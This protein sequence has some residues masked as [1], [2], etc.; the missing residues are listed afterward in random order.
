MPPTCIAHVRCAPNPSSFA[1]TC[2]S[3]KS[4]RVLQCFVARMLCI[5]ASTP[6]MHA[7][8]G[9]GATHVRKVQL[10]VEDSP[11]RVAFLL[12]AAKVPWNDPANPGVPSTMKVYLETLERESPEEF[13]EYL[14]DFCRELLG[15]SCTVVQTV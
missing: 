7:Q 6:C 1:P 9:D 13:T 2:S 15:W 12:Q 3:A 8:H 14:R 11:K 4:G 10:C 5:A